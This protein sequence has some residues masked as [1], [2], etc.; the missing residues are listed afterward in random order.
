MDRYEEV[1]SN[2]QASLT[3]ISHIVVFGL[4]GDTPVYASRHDVWS[5]LDGL[6]EHQEAD[7]QFEQVIHASVPV[8]THNLLHLKDK[9]QRFGDTLI[10][11]LIMIY[12]T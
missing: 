10:S 4:H 9:S 12:L 5:G 1:E 11:D 3:Y 6:A 2:G 7:V 8:W